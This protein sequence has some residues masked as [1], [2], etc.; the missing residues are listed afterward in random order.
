MNFGKTFKRIRES[1]GLSQEY[2]AQDIVS[3]TSISKME[4][5][6][7]IPTITNA[8][9]LFKKM[10]L[11]PNEFF[12]IQNNYKFDSKTAILHQFM[13]LSE[14]TQSENISNVIKECKK[15][16]VKRFDIQVNS[17]LLVLQSLKDFEN[18]ENISNINE[19]L[20]VVW[21][22]LS[23]VDNW[24]IIDLFI[25]NNILYFFP[26]ETAYSM[27]LNAL[28]TLEDKYPYLLRLK[29]A[30]NLNLAYLSM[31]VNLMEQ[32]TKYL[33]VSM[34]LSKIINRYDLLLL[35]K[36]RLSIII[37]DYKKVQEC[38]NL[39]ALIG[40]ENLAIGAKKEVEYFL[41]ET[42]IHKS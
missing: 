1:R 29:N 4:N 9:S 35:A 11:E 39:L 25:I 17:I 34:E 24:L 13:N 20:K 8:Y 40:A 31:K 15:Y 5:D 3:R 18:G 2:V 32:A 14:T 21:E 7:Q 30:F 23:K 10:D 6:K 16:L 26:F 19:R 28:K 22:R 42:K 37:N 33:H 38:C 41:K 12:Y 27:T 36:I